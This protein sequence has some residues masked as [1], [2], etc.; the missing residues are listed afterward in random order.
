MSNMGF[1]SNDEFK[2][3][4]PERLPD[5]GSGG[6]AD[7]FKEAST[8]KTLER[9]VLDTTWAD[10]NHLPERLELKKCIE[11][12]IEDDID[13][14]ELESYL[15]KYGFDIPEI[16]KVFKEV[17]G[18]CPVRAYLDVSN[19]SIPPACVPRY[20][21][22][23]GESKNKDCDY[24]Y[25][26]PHIDKYA[27][28]GLIGFD[29]HVESEFET[30]GEA[31]EGLKKYVKDINYV[32]PGSMGIHTDI[33]QKVAS[34]YKLE[35]SLS[36]EGKELWT[37]VSSFSKEKHIIAAKVLDS[38]NDGKIS[39]SDLKAIDQLMVLADETTPNPQEKEFQKEFQDYRDSQEM[40]S[41]DDVMEQIEVPTKDMNQILED[42]YKVNLMDLTREGYDILEEISKGLGNY[43][44]TPTGQTTHIRDIGEDTDE[45][46]AKDSMGS[47]FFIVDVGDATRKVTEKILVVMFVKNGKLEFSGKF[48]GAKTGREYALTVEGL[49]NFMD[50]V[51]GEALSEFTPS[52]AP[53]S[54]Q[55][56]TDVVGPNVR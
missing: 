10:S 2:V 5:F 7:I 49:D 43:V 6:E 37:S 33:V 15:N 55:N 34:V 52:T 30:V 4:E 17:T 42:D 27:V 46:V 51:Y 18:I 24:Y 28:I 25:V 16:R 56:Y 20:N 32:T 19:Y 1:E 14:M 12:L 13:Y 36:K 45:S 35:N 40:K 22:G 47:I 44:L 23:W 9:A 39:E 53:S 8:S 48:K 11:E 54:L 29:T 41:F 38:Y 26:L 21:Y 3:S 31:R 50:D